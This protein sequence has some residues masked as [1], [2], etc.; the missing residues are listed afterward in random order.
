MD[1]ELE[2][3][4]DDL[5]AFVANEDDEAWFGDGAP[6]ASCSTVPTCC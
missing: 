3:P 1:I 6:T 4:I 5:E 2:A